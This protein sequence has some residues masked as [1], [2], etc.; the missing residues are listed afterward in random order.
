MA[1]IASAVDLAEIHSS[2]KEEHSWPN[3]TFR[4]SVS[5]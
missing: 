2:G 4:S 3:P 1:L 5:S